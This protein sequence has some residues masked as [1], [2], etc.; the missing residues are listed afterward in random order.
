MIWK[1]QEVQVENTVFQVQSWILPRKIKGQHIPF[2]KACFRRFAWTQLMSY[3]KSTPFLCCTILG[4][5][6][7]QENTHPDKQQAISLS[8][9]VLNLV[10]TWTNNIYL[11]ACD[12]KY[13]LLLSIHLLPI[14]SNRTKNT[15]VWL[16]NILF[17]L[18]K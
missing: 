4:S 8:T 10:L 18:Y 14:D 6:P 1:Y 15:F 2:C 16:E 5:S 12:W 3:P 9:L 13:P 17:N 7:A 11:G